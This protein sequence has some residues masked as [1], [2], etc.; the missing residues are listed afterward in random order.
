MQKG[1]LAYESCFLL[2]NNE[3]LLKSS[4]AVGKGRIRLEFD[5]IRKDGGVSEIVQVKVGKSIGAYWLCIEQE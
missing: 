5:T 2:A 1:K 4:K 3:Q